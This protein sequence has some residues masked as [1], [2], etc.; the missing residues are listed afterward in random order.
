M[1]SAVSEPASKR[2]QY[3]HQN[4]R[5]C[6]LAREVERGCKQRLVYCHSEKA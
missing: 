4:E 2:Q 1:R 3:G 5:R 6:Y